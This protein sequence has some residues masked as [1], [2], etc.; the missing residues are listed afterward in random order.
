M[1]PTVM[2]PGRVIDHPHVETFAMVYGLFLVAMLLIM[3]F[4]SVVFV[5]VS[6]CP[7]M[8]DIELIQNTVLCHETSLFLDRI[9]ETIVS[10]RQ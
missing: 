5:K 3:V 7:I 4:R 6:G 9:V 10:S 1:D 2:E 8:T